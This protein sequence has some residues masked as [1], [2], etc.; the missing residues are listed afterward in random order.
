[1]ETTL[2]QNLI[3]TDGDFYKI[4]ALV[5]EHCGINL[6]ENKKQLV[7]SR[8]AKRLRIGGFGTIPEY[9]RHVLNDTTGRE[10]SSLIDSLSTNVTSF[11]REPKHFEFLC[12]EF[13]PT[14]LKRKSMRHN[15]KIRCWSAACSSGE[16]PYSLAIT[17]LDETRDKGR[18]DIKILATDISTTI[19]EM[20]QKGIYSEERIRP[21]STLQRNR[22]LTNQHIQGEKVYEVD[23]S[24][25]DTV[26]FKY[27][28]LMEAWPIRVPLDFI[29]CR[30]V[31][32]YFDKKTQESLVN[33]FWDQL[34]SGGV[35]FTGHSESLTG[36]QHKF[37]YVQPTIYLKP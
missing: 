6:T 27:L 1:M 3:L 34:D 10:F 22:Y 23:K 25:R 13:L 12:Q 5:Y 16:E 2:V 33:R 18:W 20:A 32:I 19:L 36:I 9:M 35:L 28:N 24:L 26:T 15:A 21:V 7:R 17:L 37:K 8:L 30:N 14:L 4:K 29:F 31:M 11:F